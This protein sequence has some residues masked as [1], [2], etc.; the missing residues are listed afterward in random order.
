MGCSFRFIQKI[1]DADER[2]FSGFNQ[3]PLGAV[4]NP[5][6]QGLKNL[7]ALCLRFHPLPGV[8]H[9]DQFEI[10]P[11]GGLVGVMRLPGWPET[12]RGTPSRNYPVGRVKRYTE[13]RKEAS[14]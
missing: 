14:R 10:A 7:A 5:P 13:P 9:G 3:A 12:P 11:D 6:L 2:R 1:W 8:A 4:S